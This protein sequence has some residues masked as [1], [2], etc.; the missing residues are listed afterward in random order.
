MNPF[1]SNKFNTNQA[2]VIDLAEE[3]KLERE[4]QGLVELHD[5]LKAHPDSSAKEAARFMPPIDSRV[6]NKAIQMIVLRDEKMKGGS[7]HK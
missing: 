5:F 1:D 7:Q 4:A 3:Q 2:Q 6:V